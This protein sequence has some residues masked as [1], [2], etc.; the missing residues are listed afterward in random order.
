MSEATERKGRIEAIR[1]FANRNCKFC[2]NCGE[3]RPYTETI[4]WRGRYQVSIRNGIRLEMTTSENVKFVNINN[5]RIWLFRKNLRV[6]MKVD[7]FSCYSCHRSFNGD[8]YPTFKSLGILDDY[9]IVLDGD[10]KYTRNET[11]EDKFEFGVPI[12]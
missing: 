8:P 5:S 7:Y 10:P 11:E 9:H 12:Q 3:E 6:Y 1:C 4:E 2:P